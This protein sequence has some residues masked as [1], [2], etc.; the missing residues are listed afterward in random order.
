MQPFNLQRILLL[1]FFFC[2]FKVSKKTFLSTMKQSG[3]L[4]AILKGKRPPKIT[5]VITYAT[6]DD[7]TNADCSVKDDNSCKSFLMHDLLIVKDD[8]IFR[9]FPYR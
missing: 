5:R 6:S 4:K 2:I 9:V 7:I 3:R 1:Q 8:D